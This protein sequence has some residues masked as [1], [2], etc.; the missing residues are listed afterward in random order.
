MLHGLVKFYARCGIWDKQIF[1]PKATLEPKG[2][3]NTLLFLFV[4]TGN[5]TEILPVI[6]RAHVTKYSDYTIY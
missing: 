5:K 3:K 2:L 1:T 6:T 4:A